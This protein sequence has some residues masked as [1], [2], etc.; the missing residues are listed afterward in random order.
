MLGFGIGCLVF[1]GGFGW[2]AQGMCRAL[3]KD[4]STGT[5]WKQWGMTEWVV[6]PVIS[7]V[8]VAIT[9]LLVV[10]GILV[11]YGWIAS[12]FQPLSGKA[13]EWR[14]RA[15]SVNATATAR[16]GKIRLFKICDGG[17]AHSAGLRFYFPVELVALEG[18]TDLTVFKSICVEQVA[19]IGSDQRTKKLSELSKSESLL[20]QLIEQDR[21]RQESV[22]TTEKNRSI[23]AVTVPALIK[24]DSSTPPVVVV[25]EVDAT[26]IWCS[27]VRQPSR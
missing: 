16:P 10:G 2:A 26:R 23:T 1:S 14:Q 20:N 6:G 12:F 24:V 7:I 17:G 27:I 21:N 19:E 5:A 13:E 4:L 25:A 8:F 3:W 18:Q 15:T 11:V 9:L 22:P